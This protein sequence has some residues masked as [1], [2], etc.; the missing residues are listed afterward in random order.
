M[1]DSRGRTAS[2]LVLLRGCLFLFLIYCMGKKA[3]S[4]ELTKMLNQL[5]ENKGEPVASRRR[6]KYLD[7]NERTI[8]FTALDF[9]LK[10]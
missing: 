10:I 5:K 3:Y 7:E 4:V 9:P 6:I 8:Y 2:L 1:N